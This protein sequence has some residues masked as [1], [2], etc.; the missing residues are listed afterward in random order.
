LIDSDSKTLDL[1]KAD[2]F[3]LG[4]SVYELCLGRFLTQSGP[5]EPGVA[6][7]TEE[8]DSGYTV[9]STGAGNMTEEAEIRSAWQKLR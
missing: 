5:V 4:A 2:I 7:N 9:G 3:S 8:E 6:S 1:T